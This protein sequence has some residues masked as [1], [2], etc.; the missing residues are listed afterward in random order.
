MLP[1]IL[2][3]V[4]ASALLQPVYGWGVIGHRVIARIAASKI[5]DEGVR[6]RV[7]AALDGEEAPACT[8]Q[9]LGERLACISSWADDV[10]R[11]TMRFTA[12]WHFVDIPMRESAYVEARDC[13]A[14]TRGDCLINAVIRQRAVLMNAGSPPQARA[15]A[16]KFLVHLIGDLTQPLHCI[17]DGDAGGNGKVATWFGESDW[18]YGH[19]NLHSVWDDGMPRRSTTP[20]K[21][22]AGTRGVDIPYTAILLKRAQPPT[23]GAFTAEHLIA[24]SVESH[25]LAVVQAYGMLPEPKQGKLDGPEHT[26]RLFYDLGPE[27]LARNL[28]T[29]ELQLQ[30]AGQRLADLLNDALA[31]P[32]GNW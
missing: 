3:L 26:D 22:L 4:L 30:R 27:Y 11:T 18:E 15:E 25:N 6:A 8:G 19:W 16:V 23:Q 13:R 14:T 2:S 28:P 20:G 24:W 9:D 32:S 1:R 7:L 31:A 17:T 5:T 21:N 10:R 12:N 29:V